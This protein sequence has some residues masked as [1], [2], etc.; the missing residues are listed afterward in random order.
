MLKKLSKWL[1]VVL[2][3]LHTGWVLTCYDGG[4]HYFEDGN[5]SK[6]LWHLFCGCI[7]A[8]LLIGF[9]MGCAGYDASDDTRHG[10]RGIYLA[11]ELGVLFLFTAKI[12]G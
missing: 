8:L 4:W 7:V 6:F 9:G 2:L 5:Y 12:Y 3:V 1:D 11:V 10:N